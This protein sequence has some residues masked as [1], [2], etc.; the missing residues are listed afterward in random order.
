MANAHLASLTARH[1]SLDATL[2]AEARRPMPDQVQ[3]AKLKRE[4]LRLKE[5][6][7]RSAAGA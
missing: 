7:G 2:A 5:E 1:A 6:I 3:L 4:K